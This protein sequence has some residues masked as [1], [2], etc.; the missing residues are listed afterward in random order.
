MQVRTVF[1]LSFCA[2]VM[3]VLG[4]PTSILPRTLCPSFC[5]SHEDRLRSSLSHP[6]KA[7]VL[8][9][10]TVSSWQVGFTLLGY[11][12]GSVIAG[13]DVRAIFNFLW[14]LHTV[15]QSMLWIAGA[16]CFRFFPWWFILSLS[17]KQTTFPKL[18]LFSPCKLEPIH[19]NLW[20]FLGGSK[21]IC[22]MK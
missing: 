9:T 11:L 7:V 13:S 5:L 4:P 12:W 6:D 17:W 2:W 3:L 19:L 1:C 20:L 8:I 15:S 18:T 10:V 21:K 14:G 22:Y 16:D